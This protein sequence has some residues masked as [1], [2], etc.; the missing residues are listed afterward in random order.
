MSPTI[1]SHP[2]S[3]LPSSPLG[4]RETEDESL[5]SVYHRVYRWW[6]YSILPDPHFLY[7]TLFPT[8]QD[9]SEKTWLQIVLSVLAIP[10][11]FCFTI[12]LPVVDNEAEDVSEIKLL[13]GPST[14][15]VYHSPILSAIESTVIPP[16]SPDGNL[17]V[18]RGWNRWIT[19]V[20]CICA[21][22][23]M[24]FIFFGMSLGVYG[25]NNRK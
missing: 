8:L 7:I 17:A 15:N 20:Q 18:S 21:P 1:Y 23:F 3:P 11:V 12:T 6:P 4:F 13:S 25:V 22:L 10:A 24:T 19:G 5:H 9:F 14:P 2:S 16:M